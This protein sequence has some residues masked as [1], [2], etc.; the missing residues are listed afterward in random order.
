MEAPSNSPHLYY[1][2]IN[3]GGLAPRPTS[4][5]SVWKITYEGRLGL[6]VLGEDHFAAATLS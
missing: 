5:E 3:T 2:E 6:E 4:D 1:N